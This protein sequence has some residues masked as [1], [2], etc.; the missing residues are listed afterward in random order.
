MATAAALIVCGLLFWGFAD[1]RARL[2]TIYQ[3]QVV[4]CERA[5]EVRTILHL[6]AVPCSQIVRRP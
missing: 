2:N 4:L 5:Q 6:T 1:R 3:N